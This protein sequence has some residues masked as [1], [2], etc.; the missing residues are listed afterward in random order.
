MQV[1]NSGLRLIRGVKIMAKSPEAFFDRE[2]ST[3]FVMADET[4][5]A[6]N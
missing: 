2:N 5:C 4:L 3:V 1:E 6:G